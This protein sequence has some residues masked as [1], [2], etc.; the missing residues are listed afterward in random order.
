MGGAGRAAAL[1]GLAAGMTA[2]AGVA[3]GVAVRDVV[4]AAVGAAVDV[5]VGV[6][7][8]IFPTGIAGAVDAMATAAEAAAAVSKGEGGA[9]WLGVAAL[10]A[11]APL[12]RVPLSAALA[13]RAVDS[14]TEGAEATGLPRGLECENELW[15]LP[16]AL[17]AGI[18]ASSVSWGAATRV[19]SSIRARA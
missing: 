7:D 16:E 18:P 2:A 17:A 15:E 14:A 19:P 13:W 6:E 10:G 8:V 4:E 1:A 12:P 9:D 5:L 11:V 3:D